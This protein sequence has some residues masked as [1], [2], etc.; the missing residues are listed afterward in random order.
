[1]NGPEAAEQMKPTEWQIRI[2]KFLKA[3]IAIPVYFI[4]MP[5]LFA[6]DCYDQNKWP[7]EYWR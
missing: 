7:W 5:L 1:V 4:F 3:M 2:Q 6:K